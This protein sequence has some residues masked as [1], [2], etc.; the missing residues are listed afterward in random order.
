MEEVLQKLLEAEILSIDT[1]KD[2]EDAF[3]SKLTEAIEEVKTITEAE[4]KVKLSEQW[5]VERDALI[6]AIDVKVTDFLND[7]FVELKEDINRFRDLEVEYA[8]KLTEAK[9]EM[10]EELQGDMV[11]LVEKLDTF[12]E[13][14]LVSELS[15]LR[16][17]IQE[18]KENVFGRKIFEAVSKEFENSYAKDGDLSNTLSETK[19]RLLDTEKAL[20]ESDAKLAKVERLTKLDEV[21]KPLDGRKREVMEAILVNVV[22]DQL[23]EAYNTFIDRVLKETVDA[24]NDDIVEVETVNENNTEFKKRTIP[25]NLKVI[26]GDNVQK[27]SEETKL[28]TNQLSEE[29]K[30]KLRKLAGI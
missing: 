18:Q 28:E 19:D 24:N 25:E 2:L 5:V 3:Q 17:D 15:E 10:A 30:I 21:L 7:E 8:E 14:R 16:E 6:E 23:G 22:T 4:V 29:A 1:K 12:L 9:S 13:I 27:L 20:K 11:Q 26:T